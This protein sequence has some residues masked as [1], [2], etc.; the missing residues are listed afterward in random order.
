MRRL[1]G[2]ASLLLLTSPFVCAQRSPGA[3]RMI[4]LYVNVRVEKGAPMAEVKVELLSTTGTP[5]TVTYTDERGSAIVPRVLPGSDYTLRV[6]GDG[7][8]TVVQN[9]EVQ[10][11]EMNHTEWVTLRRTEATNESLP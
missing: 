4:D 7:V 10:P 9:F 8:D 5:I 11:Q 2:I 1:L 3:T 6:S